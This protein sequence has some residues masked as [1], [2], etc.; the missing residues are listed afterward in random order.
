M[1]SAEA[2]A[3]MISIWATEACPAGTDLLGGPALAPSRVVSS[4]AMGPG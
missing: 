1:P 4:S 3:P 2:I